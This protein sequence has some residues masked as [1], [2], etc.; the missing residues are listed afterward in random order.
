LEAAKIRVANEI[1]GTVR[2]AVKS[3]NEGRLTFAD[4]ANAEAQW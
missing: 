1:E 3:F 4:K 2:D